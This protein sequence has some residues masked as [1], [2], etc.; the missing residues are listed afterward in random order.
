VLR[1]D[2]PASARGNV[3]E[4]SFKVGDPQTAQQAWRVVTRALGLAIVA[5]P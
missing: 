2:T 3:R 4:G 5:T 1:L